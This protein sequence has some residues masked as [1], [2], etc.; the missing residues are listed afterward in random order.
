MS[1]IELSELNIYPVKS[2]RGIS[3]TE[4]LVEE[5]G[6]KHDR[7]WM[8]IDKNGKFM[9]QREFPRM[10]T[11]NIAVENGS[12]QVLAEGKSPFEVPARP[13]TGKR[14]TVDVWGRPAEVEEF[15]DSVNLKFSEYLDVACRLLYMSDSDTRLVSKEYAIREGDRVS[16]A[17]GYPFLLIGEG[18]LQDLNSHL[19]S[20]VPMNRFRP[21]FVVKGTEPFA[22][23]TWK[24]IRIGSTIF[25]LVKP[26]A[27]CVTTTVDQARGEFTGT[28]PLR[29]LALYRT[30]RT[31]NL[32]GA[33]FGQNLIAENFGETI[34]VGD[35]VE[36]LE[37]K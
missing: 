15:D 12:L 22:E 36:I 2:L 29:T 25:H 33:M 35:E 24:K 5:R 20:Q 19:E 21:N 32:N 28:D 10:A 37:T 13:D 8:L 17:D 1:G 9:T 11:I 18:S 31:E 14:V 30:V 6:L 4:A 34:S 26:C 7:R 27:R 3:L 16:F 23:D